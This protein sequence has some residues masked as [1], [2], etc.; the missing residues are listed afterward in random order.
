MAAAM[1]AS[2]CLCCASY[3]LGR[4][5]IFILAEILAGSYHDEDE[6]MNVELEP[7]KIAAAHANPIVKVCKQ[8]A[9]SYPYKR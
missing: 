8:Q 2:E 6:Q 1:V 5:S 9:W 3:C 7:C 4:L